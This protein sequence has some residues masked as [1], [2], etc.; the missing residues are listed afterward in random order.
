MK[1]PILG[2]IA[3]L[4]LC[5]VYRPANAASFGTVTLTPGELRKIDIGPTGRSL[6]VCNDLTSAGPVAVVIGD[7][8]PHALSPGLCAE[9]LGSRMTIQSHAVGLATVEFKAICDGMDMR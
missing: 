1:P 2:M 7:N 8:I 5:L 9:D 6:R 4:G 3:L